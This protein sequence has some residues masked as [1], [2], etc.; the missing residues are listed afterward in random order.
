MTD[1]IPTLAIRGDFIELYKILKLENM[2]E[3]GGEA[4][5]RISQG[6]VLVNGK[7]ETRKRRKT[8][9][10]DV[11]EFNGEKVLVSQRETK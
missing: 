7:V 5:F 2:V 11:V 10:G 4:K 1:A 6:Q 3:S 8:V 9:P